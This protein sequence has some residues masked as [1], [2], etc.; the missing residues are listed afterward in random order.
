MQGSPLCCGVEWAWL[1]WAVEVWSGMGGVGVGLGAA[2]VS[3]SCSASL[4][5]SWK[6]LMTKK[7]KKSK[8]SKRRAR[9]EEQTASSQSKRGKKEPLLTWKRWPSRK[10]SKRELQT[11]QASRCSVSTLHRSPEIGSHSLPL[12]TAE[13]PNK[14]LQVPLE[15]T[16][17]APTVAI[18]P[19]PETRAPS[20]IMSISI[21]TDISLLELLVETTDEQVPG[22]REMTPQSPADI[23]RARNSPI[24][25][26]RQT[27]NKLLASY[28]EMQAGHEWPRPMHNGQGTLGAPS[29]ILPGEPSFPPSRMEEQEHQEVLEEQEHQEVQEDRLQPQGPSPKKS[30]SRR[31]R[32]GCARLWRC[33]KAWGRRYCCCLPPA[34]EQ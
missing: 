13:S 18:V 10:M 29:G 16:D 17:V 26:S 25:I 33:L 7:S 34:V 6:K 11:P 23:Q 14:E 5:K 27:W 4:Q 1:G 3:P 2:P 31:L 19:A 9:L 30:R 20:R 15:S 21:S 22:Q 24:P 28:N 12:M 8:K 32:E